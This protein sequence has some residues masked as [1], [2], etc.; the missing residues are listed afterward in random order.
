MYCKQEGKSALDIAT[1]NEGSMLDVL[2]KE[3][4]YTDFAED[5]SKISI[6]SN[7]LNH[8]F[9]AILQYQSNLTACYM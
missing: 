8:I 1:E 7:F 5:I 6:M 2:Q 9:H 4:V 3:K